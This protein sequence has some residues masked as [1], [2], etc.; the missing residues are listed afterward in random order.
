MSNPTD[1]SRTLLYLSNVDVV[2][3]GP[4]MAET[5][6]LVESILKARGHG[7]LI[8]PPKVA[9]ELVATIAPGGTLVL[10]GILASEL[11]KVRESFIAAA[12]GWATDSRV[13][14]EWSDLELG[15]PLD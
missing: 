2:S 7:E 10:S 13:L 8:M 14:G 12:P 11:D 9:R 3:I 5:I 4:T 1:R 6:P 15:R